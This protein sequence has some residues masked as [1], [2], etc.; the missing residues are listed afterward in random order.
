MPYR[1]A[2]ISTPLWADH[3]KTKKKGVVAHGEEFFCEEASGDMLKTDDVTYTSK[4]DDKLANGDGWIEAKNCVSFSI[5]DPEVDPPAPN[6]KRYIITVE[7]IL[8]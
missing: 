5:M 3:Q 1:V 2:T 7:E 6:K 4:V 8:G